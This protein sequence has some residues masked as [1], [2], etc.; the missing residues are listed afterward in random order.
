MGQAERKAE[1]LTTSEGGLL[2]LHAGDMRAAG[3]S[4][5]VTAFTVVLII[6]SVCAFLAN[7]GL[8]L[9]HRH[10]AWV[11]PVRL[12]AGIISFAPLV[13][14]VLSKTLTLQLGVKLGL[15]TVA[16][17]FIAIGVFIALTLMVPAWVDRR[18]KEPEQASKD[19]KAAAGKGRVRVLN[20]SD[21]WVN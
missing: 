6:I 12:L 13:G 17:A 18:P 8:G 5:G 1:A 9:L 15:N 14:L 20:G 4:T 19:P 11:L 21:E 16:N 3:G 10:R 2:A 7:V